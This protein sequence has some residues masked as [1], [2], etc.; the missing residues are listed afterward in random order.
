MRSKDKKSARGWAALLGMLFLSV[1][2]LLR[3]AAI[4]P[5]PNLPPLPDQMDWDAAIERLSQD[6][7]PKLSANRR[8]IV[9]AELGFGRAGTN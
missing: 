9:E 2:L 1:G 4:P 8:F 6:A 5:L 3:A 7:D